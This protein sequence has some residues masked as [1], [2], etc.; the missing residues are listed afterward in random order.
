MVLMLAVVTLA[1]VA[2][3]G[4]DVKRLTLLILT[5]ALIVLSSVAYVSV[6]FNA[7]T[8]FDCTKLSDGNFYVD[9]DLGTTPLTFFLCFSAIV[10]RDLNLGIY[11]FAIPQAVVVPRRYAMLQWPMVEVLPCWDDERASLRDRHAGCLLP[12]ALP[13]KA[14]PL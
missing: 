7:L 2:L 12:N 3:S 1:A 14:S 8:L 5:K 11:W 13:A 9:A 6:S 10:L 4:Q